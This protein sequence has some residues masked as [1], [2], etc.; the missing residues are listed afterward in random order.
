MN[1]TELASPFNACIFGCST[2]NTAPS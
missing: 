1:L 2:C